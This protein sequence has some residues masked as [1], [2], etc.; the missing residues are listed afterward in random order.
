MQTYDAFPLRIWKSKFTCLHLIDEILKDYNAY[1][2]KSYSNVGGW[3]SLKHLH[4]DSRFLPLVKE[5][6][7]VAIEPF[8]YYSTKTPRICDMWSNVNP[9]GAL[10][11]PHDHGNIMV[12]SGVAYFQT[13]ESNGHL[14]FINPNPA[15]KFSVLDVQNPTTGQVFTIPVSPGDLIFFPCWLDHYT[16]ANETDEMRAC[17]AFN[18]GAV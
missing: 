3:Q 9:P 12:L 18:I 6:M 17:V 14:H 10:N 13:N 5:I 1:P 11:Q 16:S 2:E 7:D 8:R 4:T 15:A